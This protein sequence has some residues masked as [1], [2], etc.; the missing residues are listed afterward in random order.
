MP[1]RH[2]FGPILGRVAAVIA[3]L[4]AFGLAWKFVAAILAP[5][6]PGPVA[7]ALSAGWGLFYSVVQ[8]AVPAAIAV[9]VLCAIGWV[10]I[11]SRR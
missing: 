11:G 8:P 7:N 1:L 4:L 9:G 5:V 6:L 3:I 2:N 10:V